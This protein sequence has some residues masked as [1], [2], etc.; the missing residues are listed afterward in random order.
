MMSGGTNMTQREQETEGMQ[1]AEE[2][3]MVVPGS[4]STTSTTND[5]QRKKDDAEER[6][7]VPIAIE[8]KRYGSKGMLHD[9]ELTARSSHSD[10]RLFREDAYHHERKYKYLP[11][12]QQQLPLATPYGGG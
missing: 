12:F 1:E 6:A 5:E 7:L 4:S 11:M 2:E 9:S 3:E 8:G 10:R